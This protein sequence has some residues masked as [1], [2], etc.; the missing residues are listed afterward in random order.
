MLRSTLLT[1]LLQIPPP[2]SCLL[3]AIA[4]QPTFLHTHSPQWSWWFGPA[5][6]YDSDGVHSHRD[7]H[8]LG[9]GTY[10]EQCPDLYLQP[11]SLKLAQPAVLQALGGPTMHLLQ[12]GPTYPC[13]RAARPWRNA[14]TTMVW[15]P[16]LKS[17]RPWPCIYHQLLT[18]NWTMIRWYLGQSKE[19]ISHTTD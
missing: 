7:S 18:D 4:S 16:A 15:A 3:E 9:C 11:G 10:C 12:M 2:L 17:P 6:P 19:E 14:N 8:G 1:L 13:V 5:R